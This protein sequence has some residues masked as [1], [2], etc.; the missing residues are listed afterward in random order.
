[1]TFST[2]TSSGERE[3]RGRMCLYIFVPISGPAE[4]HFLRKSLLTV[5]KFIT[6]DFAIVNQANEKIHILSLL[7]ESYWYESHSQQSA[8]LLI[9]L[10][11]KWWRMT[12]RKWIR[13]MKK[14]TL[15]L[16]MSFI[17]KSFATFSSTAYPTH[18]KGL[19]MEEYYWSKSWLSESQLCPHTAYC[20]WSVT[21]S[22][23]NLNR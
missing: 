14:I 20:I 5:A 23:S 8:L 21:S 15:S 9:R 7:S 3:V 6:N 11:R 2:K 1:M 18:P 13:R 4:G 16:W 17:W 12:L 10:I 22:F 19:P